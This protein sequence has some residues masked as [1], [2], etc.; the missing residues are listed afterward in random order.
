MY[1]DSWLVQGRRYYRVRERFRENGRPRH[2]T[3]ISLGTH[4]TIE[5]AFRDAVKRY[6]DAR[7]GRRNGPV[8]AADE[9]IWDRSNQLFNLHLQ[10]T[11]Q[12]LK[13][14]ARVKA[15]DKRRAREQEAQR[16]ATR[17]W[18]IPGW[19][20]SILGLPEEATAAEIRAARDRKARECHPDHGGS[21]EAMAAVNEAYESLTNRPA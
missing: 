8:T 21:D 9:K 13:L 16:I 12:P 1:I 14:S 7:K 4:P 3:L 20:R 5:A 18:R 2:R 11:G 10:W 15:E 6:F 17:L 19:C